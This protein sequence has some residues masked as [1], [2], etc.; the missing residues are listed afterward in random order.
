MSLL[1][2][3]PDVPLTQGDAGAGGRGRRNGGH[4][5]GLPRRSEAGTGRRRVPTTR[6]GRPRQLTPGG[7]QRA[8][9]EGTLGDI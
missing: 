8:A 4:P 1:T 3:A 5:P 6:R 2:P 9:V 7:G